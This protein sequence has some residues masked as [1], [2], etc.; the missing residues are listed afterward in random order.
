MLISTLLF[1]FSIYSSG[2]QELYPHENRKSGNL[3][4]THAYNFVGVPIQHIFF[5]LGISLALCEGKRVHRQI[6][7]TVREP[8]DNYFHFQF[9]F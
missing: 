7:D 4:K 9:H 3:A 5:T 1:F 2:T 8:M 6:T